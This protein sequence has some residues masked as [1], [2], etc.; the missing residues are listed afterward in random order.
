MG[1][2]LLFVSFLSIAH[3]SGSDKPQKSPPNVFVD[4]GACPFECCTYR[5]WRAT[6]RTTAFSA[7]DKSSSVLNSIATGTQIVALT[8]EVHTTAGRFLVKRDHNQYKSGDVLFVYTPKGEGFFKVWF[9]G[10]MYEEQLGFSSEGGFP[11][12]R[13][14]NSALCWGQLES[15]LKSVWWVKVKLPSGRI[16]WIKDTQNFTGKD[17]CG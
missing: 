13:C 8:G 12:S 15:E 9:G 7:P 2:N 3:L 5:A 6:K 1:L 16:V 14:S 11:D 17:G 4:K 10:R